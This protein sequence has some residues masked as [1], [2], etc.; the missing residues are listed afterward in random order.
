[1][2]LAKSGIL[3]SMDTQDKELSAWT[4][5]ELKVHACHE[6]PVKKLYQLCQPLGSWIEI[7]SDNGEI[8]KKD[9]QVCIDENRQELIETPLW[10][11]LS[12]RNEEQQSVR[13]LRD[14]HIR[15]V[16]WFVVNG[17]RDPID[18]DVGIPSLPGGW[19]NH[20]LEDG[21]HR[22]AAAWVRGDKTIQAHVS[23]AV[24]HA[25]ELGFWN[26]N[27][28]EAELQKRYAATS[29]RKRRPG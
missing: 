5:E 4:V 13:L 6:L 24:S 22:L 23:G 16:A 1:M 3:N 9:I 18:L 20:I 14:N 2:L 21:H 10:T 11:T 28:F 17:I 7:H 27:K 8:R 26:P 12:K 19:V 29:H 15:K 25:T